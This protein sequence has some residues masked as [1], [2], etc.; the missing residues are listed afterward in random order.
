MATL[1]PE[2]YEP[3]APAGEDVGKEVVGRTP[4]Q[5]FWVRFKADRAAL[6]GLGAIIFLILLA[7]AAPLIVKITGHGPND[8]YQREMTDEFG[9]PKG[10]NKDFWFGADQAGRDVFVRVDLR[11]AHV[12][13]RRASSRPASRSSSGRSSASS[14]ASSAASSTRSSRGRST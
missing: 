10:P 13:H 11:R 2:T 8:L 12:A 3:G 1:A 9:L 6:V 5:L 4:F 14:P 7:F